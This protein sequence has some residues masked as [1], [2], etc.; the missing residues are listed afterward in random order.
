MLFL[1]TFVG[2]ITDRKEV[3]SD[4][5]QGQSYCQHYSESV[6]SPISKRGSLGSQSCGHTEGGG[7]SSRLCHLDIIAKAG[8]IFRRKFSSRYRKR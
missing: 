3:V 2:T 4:N 5:A 7:Y 6:P 1:F 8:E